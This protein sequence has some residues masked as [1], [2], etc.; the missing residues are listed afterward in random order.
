MPNDFAQTAQRL[1]ELV[2]Q[3]SLSSPRECAAQKLKD[4]RTKLGPKGVAQAIPRPRRTLLSSR[5]S[6]SI[7]PNSGGCSCRR[8]TGREHAEVKKA[9]AQLANSKDK[10]NAALMGYSGP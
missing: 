4:L 5:S 8:I 10:I 3:R 6:N 7:S 2:L 1:N 9:I